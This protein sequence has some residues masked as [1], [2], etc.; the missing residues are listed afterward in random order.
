MAKD[1]PEENWAALLPQ[2]RRPGKN[3]F[4]GPRAGKKFVP[5]CL[6]GGESLKSGERGESQILNLLPGSLFN[7]S[8]APTGSTRRAGRVSPAIE[9]SLAAT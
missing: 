4:G 6:T 8:A 1:L 5:A 3:N 7:F 2:T 9:D